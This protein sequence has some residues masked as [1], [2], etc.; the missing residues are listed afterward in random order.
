MARLVPG[1]EV[2][3]EWLAIVVFPVSIVTGPGSRVTRVLPVVMWTLRMLI[4]AVAKALDPDIG[5]YQ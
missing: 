3:L 1:D 4:M 2:P 5:V